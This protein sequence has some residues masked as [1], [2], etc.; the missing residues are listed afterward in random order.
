V[1][2][3]DQNVVTV[4]ILGIACFG[5]GRRRV[6]WDAVLASP[7]FSLLGDLFPLPVKDFRPACDDALGK[8]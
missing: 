3:G 5:G 6:A 8:N 2:E 7:P 4:E 1:V